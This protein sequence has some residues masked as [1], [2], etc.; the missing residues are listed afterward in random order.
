MQFFANIFLDTNKMHLDSDKNVNF[1]GKDKYN[2]LFIWIKE[3]N[4][5]NF[6]YLSLTYVYIF[7][8]FIYILTIKIVN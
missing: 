8:Q 4:D 6:K 7:R 3:K 5:T 2:T 1:L